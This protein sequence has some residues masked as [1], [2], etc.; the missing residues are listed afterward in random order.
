MQRIK[1]LASGLLI[2]VIVGSLAA[3]NVSSDKLILQQI[4]QYRSWNRVTPEILKQL[5]KL[6]PGSRI[7][8]APMG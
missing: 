2:L 3:G 4:A 5:K 6:P 1:L 7:V 8:L